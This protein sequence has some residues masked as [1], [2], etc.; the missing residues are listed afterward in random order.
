[1]SLLPS[2]TI[3]G[4][5]RPSTVTFQSHIFTFHSL[6]LDNN[7]QSLQILPEVLWLAWV[8][9][10]QCHLPFL[11]KVGNLGTHAGMAD[12]VSLSAGAA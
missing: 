7:R 2:F 6:F 12:L 9:L 1:M 8:S 5:V 3:L 4:S 11:C 10:V